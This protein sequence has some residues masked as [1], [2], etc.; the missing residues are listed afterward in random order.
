M[1][2]PQEIAR[3][4]PHAPGVYIYKNLDNVV[5]YVGKAKDLKRRVMQYFHRD[6]AVGA[7]TRL[8]VSQIAH[9]ET[10][11]TQS[12]FDALL[13]EAKRIHDFYPKYN[14]VAKDDKSPLYVAI[15]MDEELPRILFVRKPKNESACPSGKRLIFG[16]FQSGRT[17]RSILRLLRRVV[18]YCSQKIRNGK[19]CFYTHLGLCDPCPSVIL[20]LPDSEEK[21]TLTRLYRK[22]I[23]HIADILSGKS[24]AVLADME[25]EMHTL[26]NHNDFE[27]A[28]TVKMSIDRLNEIHTHHYDPSLYIEN[29]SFLAH[30]TEQQIDD[31]RKALQP[32]FP[33][34]APLH[35]IECVDVSNTPGQF[36]AASLVVLSDGRPDTSLYRRFHI[37][38][39]DTS[40]DVAM[41]EEVIRRRFAH[42]EWS[43]PDLLVI[44]GGKGQLQSALG[45]MHS[46]GIHLPVVGLAKRDEEIIVF[47]NNRYLVLRLPRTSP[48]LHLVQLVRDESHRFALSYHKKLRA[49]AFLGRLTTTTQFDTITKHEASHKSLPF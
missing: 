14:V 46:L 19:P 18:P 22:H 15:T 11:R 12:E 4:L 13:L 16:P 5:L 30:V 36:A 27:K 28:N 33:D 45:A 2:T 8:L 34:M 48:A 25:K 44:D 40:S 7:K 47:D 3:S 23:R 31:L 24:T 32:F 43:Y 42:K 49:K 9:I 10:I 20:R 29:D 37:R 35:R 17:I 6:D 1:E 38:S 39:S 26:A 41:I 21:K